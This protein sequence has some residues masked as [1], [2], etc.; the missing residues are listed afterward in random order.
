MK[1]HSELDRS[2]YTVSMSDYAG[3]IA[4]RLGQMIEADA[5]IAA[6][7]PDL[8]LNELKRT[9]GLGLAQIV[10]TCMEGYA[11]RPA[12][13][14]RAVKLSTD[15]VTGRTAR[16]VEKHFDTTTYGELWERARRLATYWHRDADRPLGADEF[17]CILGFGS[18][19]FVTVDLAAIHNGAVVVPIQ[20]NAAFQQSLSV[21]NEVAPSWLAVGLDYIDVGVELVLQGHRPRGLLVFDYRAEVDDE[22]ER[23][24]AAQA[25]LAAVGLD[26]LLVTLE[27]AS[28]KGAALPKAPVFDRPDTNERLSTIYYTSGS[29]GLPKGAMLPER[30]I[31]QLWLVDSPLPMI[32]LI[33][34]PMNHTSGRSIVFSILGLGGI[35]YFTGSKDLS[36]LFDD[37]RV[38]RPTYM[39][40]VPRV[41]EMIYQQY[42]VARDRRLAAGGDL[43]AVERDLLREVRDELLGGRLL[44]ASFAS[45]PLA[46]ELAQF[47]NECLGF[48]MGNNYGATE[49]A[50]VLSNNRILRPPVIEYRLDDVPELGYFKTDKPHPRGEL[51]IKTTSV[52]LGY[53]KRPDATAAVFDD[54][55]YYKT[56]DIMEEVAPDHLIY[57]D[58]RNNVLKL[59]QGEFVAIS[60]LE[61][62][63]TNGDPLIRQAYLYGTSE[64]AFLVGVFVPDEATLRQMGVEGDAGAIKQ[65]LREAIQ[66]VARSEKLQSYEVP[67]DFIVE[68]EPFSAENGL[69]AGIGKYQRPRFKERYGDKLEQL[70]DHI[71]AS[72]QGELEALRREGGNLPVLETV[73]RAMKATLGLESVDPSQKT[74]FSDLGGDS[75]SAVGFSLLLEEIY[76]V[77]VP[78]SVINHPAGSLQRLAKFI[79][80]AR[81]GASN[82]P[83]FASVHGANADEIR[84]SDL[85]LGRFIDGGLLE[86]A[87]HALPPATEVRKVFMTGANGFLGRFLCLEWLE[88][89]AA[90]G[91]QVVCVA[92][93]RDAAAARQ[94]IADAFASD[95]QLKTRFEKLAATHLEVLAGDL[96]EPQLGLSDGDWEQLAKSVDL[97]VH[98]AALVN[99]ILPYQQL[100]GPNVVGTAEVIRLAITHRLKPI[101][102]VSTVAAAFLPDGAI[103]DE[104]ADVRQ[105]TPVRRLASGGYADGYANSKWAAE[106]LLRDAHERYGLP[107]AI[108]RSDMILAH[109]QYAKQLNLPDM[110]TRLIVSLVATG[111]APR[112]FYT[113]TARP[114]YPGLPVDFTAEAIVT[115]GAES[116]TGF[117]TFHVINSHDDGISLDTFV[118]WIEA[119]G[120]PIRRLDD[121]NEWYERF[122]AGLRGLP[123]EQ[124]QRSSL[125]LLQQL[126]QPIPSEIGI[127]VP[128][129][130]FR[131]DVVKYKVGKNDD[132]PHLSE[133]FIAKYLA[134]LA[135]LDAI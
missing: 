89:M 71:A 90:V 28:A 31:K 40:L 16:T 106:V 46:P 69:L 105:A 18:V 61:A 52:M 20:A 131:A 113:G 99:H 132:I 73:T 24:E 124:R 91:G 125:P 32:N 55:G 118:D 68:R 8:A 39:L 103:I 96:G 21:Y 83:S 128:S 107:V 23:L 15:P 76:G 30:M 79:E 50:A 42:T 112:S 37:M 6:V 92:R 98:P 120:Y 17:L 95:P 49:V 127:A 9:R 53:Y 82:A 22:R 27:A 126:Q 41:C 10:A 86:A 58:R 116:L 117:R 64:R 38:C 26:H 29:T 111:L 114:H 13:A 35:G 101:N 66:R 85:T 43:I 36:E 108:F 2:Q 47:M 100:F 75:L 25:R 11:G 1:S 4:S 56:G 19:D 72:Q 48:E 74:S 123:E 135:S 84:A 102:N 65:A 14:E 60:R 94:R 121:Y 134:D 88:R 110:F 54:D 59:S 12:L 44:V 45:A 78:V 51:C 33:Y 104:D 62:I 109:S 122:A 5:Q 130:R 80:R 119:A 87:R 129:E 7:M 97:I 81:E 63:F 57:V 34:M 133:S 3:W 93:G 115:L 70:Y 77:E 67:R